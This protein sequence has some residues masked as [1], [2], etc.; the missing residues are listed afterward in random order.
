MLQ[1]EYTRF[2]YVLHALDESAV[3]KHRNIAI[4]YYAHGIPS[5]F[6]GIMRISAD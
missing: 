3:V 2:E 4:A 6:E 5:K 1:S